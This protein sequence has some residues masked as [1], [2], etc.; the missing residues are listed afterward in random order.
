[1]VAKTEK[2]FER[3]KLIRRILGIT[4]D[5]LAEKLKVKRPFISMVEGARRWVDQRT[6]FRIK[7]TTGV[8]PVWLESGG[9]VPMFVDIEKGVRTLRKKGYIE[10]KHE[11][12]FIFTTVQQLYAMVDTV[13]KKE[14]LYGLLDCLYVWISLP[15]VLKPFGLVGHPLLLGKILKRL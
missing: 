14:L 5:E 11:A 10:N 9:L 8:S 15:A 1:M 13:S 4:Q 3:F 12:Y 6:L 2:M 7:E